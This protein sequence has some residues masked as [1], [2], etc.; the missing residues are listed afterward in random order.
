[1]PA[2]R[3][4]R[5][6]ETCP[7]HCRP[8]ARRAPSRRRARAQRARPAGRRRAPR[9]RAPRARP[10]A[11]PRDAARRRDAGGSLARAQHGMQ[12]PVKPAPRG[13]AAALRRQSRAPRWRRPAA[14]TTGAGRAHRRYGGVALALL[15]AAPA[16]GRQRG[17]EADL[18]LVRAA[19]GPRREAGVAK[20]ADHPMVR[21][22]RDAVEQLDAG[23][24]AESARC[25][26]SVVASPRPCHAPSTA[27]ATSASRG[28]GARVQAVSDDPL[29]VAGE[30]EQRAAV[31]RRHGVARRAVEVDAGGEEAEPARLRLEPGEEV[32]HA[33]ASSGPALRTRA[34]E[35]SRSTTSIRQRRSLIPQTPGARLGLERR[36]GA[37]D[38][39]SRS[40]PARARRSSGRAASRCRT[41]SR[42]GRRCSSAS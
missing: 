41:R 14:R 8:A 10:P 7:R 6:V 35:P 17:R 33:G 40:A 16:L 38:A 21:R 22:Q 12:V 25:A 27:N 31:G 32:A 24:A 3:Q 37:R 15:E 34:V 28:S 36:R 30:H 20:H 18:Q 26:S 13:C 9:A 4:S 39:R 23:R 42:R 5:R 19:R 1:M 29:G 2:A 11:G